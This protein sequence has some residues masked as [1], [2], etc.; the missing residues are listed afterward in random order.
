MSTA[1]SSTGEW[2]FASDKDTGNIYFYNRRTRET[3]WTLPADEG[4][5]SSLIASLAEAH[6]LLK[7]E[8]QRHNTAAAATEFPAPVDAANIKEAIDPTSHKKYYYNVKTKQSYWEDPRRTFVPQTQAVSPPSPE[9]KPDY[10]FANRNSPPPRQPKFEEEESVESPQQRTLFFN[11]RQRKPLFDEDLE[12]SPR[13]PPQ[14]KETPAVFQR[15]PVSEFVKIH[16]PQFVGLPRNTGEEEDEKEDEPVAPKLNPQ[17]FNKDHLRLIKKRMGQIQPPPPQ[18]RVIPMKAEAA[19]PVTPQ[20]MITATELNFDVDDE[21]EEEEPPVIVNRPA[22]QR[23]EI[24]KP[25]PVYVAPVK[26]RPN[27]NIACLRKSGCP[28]SACSPASLSPTQDEAP[29]K[30]EQLFP[31]ASCSRKFTARS[32]AV[33]QRVCAKVFKPASTATASKQ[34]PTPPPATKKKPATATAKWRK[35]SEEL[36]AAMQRGRGEIPAP[37]TTPSFGIADADDATTPPPIDDGLV[38]CPHCERRFNDKAAERHIP[39]CS[40]I[41]SKPKTLRRGE[42]LRS[43][44]KPSAAAASA[45]TPSVTKRASLVDRTASTNAQCPHC[46]RIFSAKVLDK[47]FESC[48]PPPP[49]FAAATPKPSKSW[50]KPLPPPPPSASSQS[51]WDDYS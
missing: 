10:K 43:A 26:Q 21:E 35:Q 27:N 50:R 7:K 32:L 9:A 3:R 30:N 29:V 33:H 4:Q 36:R 5:T 22:V 31:C 47:H 8:Q 13:T 19:A 18:Q 41:V 23:N 20:P 49:S 38:M 24:V 1:E 11:T 40:N 16:Q 15:K 12:P 39:K 28:C 37:T 48:G 45:P 51:S 44:V 34:S 25:T 42:G 6:A 17:S 14:A 2:A 46:R